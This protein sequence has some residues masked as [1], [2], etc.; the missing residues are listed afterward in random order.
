MSLI[1]DVIVLTRMRL[2]NVSDITLPTTNPE[3]E[4]AD[5]AGETPP[6]ASDGK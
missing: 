5:Q 4:P 2:P 6:A 3:D 1:V